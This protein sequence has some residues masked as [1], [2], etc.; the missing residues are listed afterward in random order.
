MEIE[1]ARAEDRASAA[2]LLQAAFADDPLLSWLIPD[3]PA[4]LVHLEAMF[5][6]AFDDAL[7]FGEL[8]VARDG[9]EL[10]GVG[11]WFPPGGGPDRDKE[12]RA[13]LRNSLDDAAKARF[14]ALGEAM[15]EHHPEDPHHYLNV[16]GVSPQRQRQ[17][18]GGRLI[19]AITEI[20]D[21]DA[22][23]AYLEATS[24]HNRRLYE[25][26][27]FEVTAPIELPDGPTIY[28]MWRT[29]R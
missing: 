16:A 28:A 10:G 19:V 4:R 27:G 2:S 21:R 17:G 8:V 11:I 1:L 18:L 20:C 7:V 3:K 6:F 5:G 24:E 22:V 26:H 12:E 23:G 14:R 15:G 25:R 29:P 9:S 13:A